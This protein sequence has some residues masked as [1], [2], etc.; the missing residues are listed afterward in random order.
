MNDLKTASKLTPTEAI[1]QGARWVSGRASDSGTIGRGFE[2]YL[3]CV[4]TLCKT[5]YSP[6]VLVIP[7]KQWLRPDMF[8]KLLTGT[9]SLNTI[10][11]R[12]NYRESQQIYG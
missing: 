2:T 12:S 9:L 8:K 11:Q 4:V 5:L 3:R 6:K 1:I 7:R 10:K